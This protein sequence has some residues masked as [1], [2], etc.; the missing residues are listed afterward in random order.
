MA[1]ATTNLREMS[2]DVGQNKSFNAGDN[3]GFDYVHIDDFDFNHQKQPKARGIK[4]QS[5]RS[6]NKSE[7][8]SRREMAYEV[9]QNKSFSVT[10][11]SA[12]AFDDLALED[13][14][15]PPIPFSQS[16]Q[17]R[18]PVASVPAK[19]AYQHED[20]RSSLAAD[21]PRTVHKRTNLTTLMMWIT[22]TLRWRNKS[23][24]FAGDQSAYPAAAAKEG[25][26]RYEV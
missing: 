16:P 11:N 8:S 3:A 1:A 25:R 23:K 17:P 20:E 18:L 2:Y 21:G 9:G 12:R 14:P 22:A 10:G 5:F 4:L 6:S 7:R 13:E 19:N 24:K 26:F 15:A